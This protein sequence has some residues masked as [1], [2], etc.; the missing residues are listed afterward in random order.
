ME[1]ALGAVNKEEDERSES[2]RFEFGILRLSLG[3]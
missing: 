2:A 1:S 3:Y